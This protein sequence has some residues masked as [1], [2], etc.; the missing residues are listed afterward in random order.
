MR[1]QEVVMYVCETGNDQKGKYGR[2]GTVSEY[3][4]V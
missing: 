2:Y 4:C 1:A 3:L